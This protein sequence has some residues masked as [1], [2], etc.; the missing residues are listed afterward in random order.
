MTDVLQTLEVEV[1]RFQAWA[2]AYPVAE[3]SGE[4]EC[5]YDYWWRLHDAFSAFVT[6]LPCAHWSTATTQMILYTIARDNETGFLVR[7]V[8]KTP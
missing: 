8:A 3:R 5:D 7:E 1:T 6:A 4:W 2:D